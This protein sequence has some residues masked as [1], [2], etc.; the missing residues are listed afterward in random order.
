MADESD[1]VGEQRTGDELKTGL[2][3][4]GTRL[5]EVEY[6]VVDGMAIVEGCIVLGR[7]DTIQAATAALKV[8]EG[9]ALDSKGFVGQGA[10]ETYGSVIKSPWYRWSAGVVPFRI[11]NSLPRPERVLE[12]M[13]HWHDHTPIRF[14]ER[15]AAQASLYPDYIT[16]RP[17]IGCSSS[18]GRQRGE[19]FI[20][21]GTDCEVGNV[22]HEIGHAVGLWHEQ[23]RIDRDQYVAIVIDKVKPKARLNFE[24]HI[25]DGTD[26][27]AYDYDSIM[28][29]PR[30]AFPIVP[31][32]ETVTPKK[33]GAEIGQR[34]GL[35][36]GDIATV[37][38]IYGAT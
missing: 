10:V 30:S 21:L 25:T 1:Q 8:S 27:G 19:Q 35:S 33:A 22:I 24:Q 11:S 2:V 28:H 13:Q 20:T 17:G 31:G 32:E 5:K 26:V 29:Y 7:D 34:R 36:A 3:W 23:S 6:A 37:Q 4:I 12:A 9:F 18:V 15:V 14:V 38:K 16:F